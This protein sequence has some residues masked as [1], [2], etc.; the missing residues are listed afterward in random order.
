[1]FIVKNHTLTVLI[2]LITF[3]G[4][5]IFDIYVSLGYLVRGYVFKFTLIGTASC[6]STFDCLLLERML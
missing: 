1:M 5:S 2:L 6:S 3:E 4:Y